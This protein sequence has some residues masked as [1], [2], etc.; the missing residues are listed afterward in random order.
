[1]LLNTIIIGGGVAGL[2]VAYSLTLHK[3]TNIMLID[4]RNIG[5]GTTGMSAATYCAPSHRELC[6]SSID[7]HLT[8]GSRR[9]FHDLQHDLGF[10][11]GLIECG[12][13]EVATSDGQRNLLNKTGMKLRDIGYDEKEVIFVED[14]KEINKLEPALNVKSIQGVLYYQYA[15]F[16]DPMLLVQGFKDYVV[17]CSNNNNNITSEIIIEDDEVIS[18]SD[19]F[20]HR[21][22][23][24]RAISPE[25]DERFLFRDDGKPFHHMFLVKLKS[26]KELFARNIVVC[27]GIWTQDILER[28]MGIY[29]SFYQQLQQPNTNKNY[30]WIIPTQA[31]GMFIHNL[32]L[33]RLIFYSQVYS[34]G[35]QFTHSTTTNNNKSEKEI[36][37]R[38]AHHTYGRPTHD[39]EN[40]A[41]FG[42]DRIPFHDASSIINHTNNPFMIKN[43][44]QQQVTE[45]LNYLRNILP[46]ISNQDIDAGSWICYMPFTFDGEPIVGE[47]KPGVFILSGL[48]PRGIERGPQLGEDLV[49]GL[50][51]KIPISDLAWETLDEFSPIR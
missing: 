31:Q 21:P 7:D 2:S 27:G 50:I 46:Q 40:I 4:G 16:V 30:S 29:H 10:N 49:C 48:G 8:I 3:K 19:R 12:A 23:L 9:I 11:I 26:G 45:N 15:G 38:I 33:K 24:C 13:L 17:G 22:F 18:V 37:K 36:K 43:S 51:C 41:F 32:S 20:A 42:F 14:K 28:V 44:Q 34:M 1:M 5:S 39:I 6:K 35:L 25:D 47:I